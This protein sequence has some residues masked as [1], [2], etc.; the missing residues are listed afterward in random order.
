[1]D[2]TAIYGAGMTPKEF[3]D[4][5]DRGKSVMKYLNDDN[6]YNT[7]SNKFYGLPIGPICNPSQMSIEAAINPAEGKYVYFYAVQG[8]DYF[9]ETSSEFYNFINS[10]KS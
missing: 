1:M 3:Q 5:V 4:L 9:F 6:P 7:R 2:S 10:L 8:R